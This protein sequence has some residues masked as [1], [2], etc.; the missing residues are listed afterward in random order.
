METG[1]YCDISLYPKSLDTPFEYDMNT[2]CIFVTGFDA[3]VVFC[4]KSDEKDNFEQPEH[5][6]WETFVKSHLIGIAFQTTSKSKTYLDRIWICKKSFEY[7]LVPHTL[8]C[9]ASKVWYSLQADIRERKFLGTSKSCLKTFCFWYNTIVV[10][11][12][13]LVCISCVVCFFLL[14]FV[15]VV[16]SFEKATFKGAI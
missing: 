15:F 6:D 7:S 16:K 3:I 4:I 10:V 11:F 12:S 13:P 2:C 1:I 8:H 9:F 14:C 5:P